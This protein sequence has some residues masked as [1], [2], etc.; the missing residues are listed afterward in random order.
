MDL[1]CLLSQSR[2]VPLDVSQDI[3]VRYSC[4]R[5]DCLQPVSGRGLAGR[6]KGKEGAGRA[7][8]REAVGN[9]ETVVSKERGRLGRQ[10][11][12]QERGASGTERLDAPASAAVWN[13]AVGS[14]FLITE[15]LVMS[16]WTTDR[17][18]SWPGQEPDTQA[19]NRRAQRWPTARHAEA[20]RAAAAGPR[21]PARG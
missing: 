13:A 14:Y 6:S 10:D 5:N 16:V 9:V 12:G 8:D 11:A 18:W 19:Q 3:C 4:I 7:R 2:C 15:A 1:P 17:R 21:V 20:P